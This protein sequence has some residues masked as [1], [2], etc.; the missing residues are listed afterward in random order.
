MGRVGNLLKRVKTG[1]TK[2]STGIMIAVGLV[3]MGSAVIAGISATPKAIRLKEEAEKKKGEPLTKTEIV[4][5]TWKG[6]IPAAATFVASSACI[7]GAN[8]LHIK[9]KAA[10]STAYALSETAFT[11]YRK[12]VK[13]IVGE[14]KEQ[15]IHDE[16]AKDSVQKN[17]PVASTVIFTERGNTL[18]YDVQFHR[19]FRSNIDRIRK[20]VNDLNFRMNTGYEEFISLNEF[21]TELGIPP[22]GPVGDDL[23][24]NVRRELIEIRYGSCLAPFDSGE[25]DTPCLTIDYL[26]QPRYD[27]R[28]LY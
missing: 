9:Q 10:L 11:E 25:E 2:H 26:A 21:Y 4:K 28:D 7:I 22:I 5:V 19:Y 20:V 23:G 18:C 1:A 17:P 3:G 14:K 16:V 8:K 12:H 15:E 27:Y 6:Y 24:W 13:E